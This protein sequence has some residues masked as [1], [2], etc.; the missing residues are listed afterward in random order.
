MN[1][2]NYTTRYSQINS[3]KNEITTLNNKFNML[4]RQIQMI[5]DSQPANHTGFS[6]LSEDIKT[7]IATLSK[8]VDVMLNQMLEAQRQLTEANTITITRNMNDVRL[9]IET[10]DIMIKFDRQPS[11]LDGYV[12]IT[13]DELNQ[14]LRVFYDY[15]HHSTHTSNTTYKSRIVEPLK[16][17]VRM[18]QPLTNLRLLVSTFETKYEFEQDALL[19]HCIN[20]I[21]KLHPSFFSNVLDN[22][23]EVH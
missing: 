9:S 22:V 12:E 15:Q 14:P 17:A 5:I 21:D 10:N 20:Q 3:I 4:A 7:T 8:N 1:R 11:N 6:E 13:C 18:K 23:E 2:I 19:S 16:L